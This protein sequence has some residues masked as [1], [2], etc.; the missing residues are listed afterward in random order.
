MENSERKEINVKPKNPELQP[1]QQNQPQNQQQLHQQQIQQ[2]PQIQQIQMQQPFPVYPQQVIPIQSYMVNQPY[3]YQQP[4]SQ[5]IIV[6]PVNPNCV[7]INQPL[8]TLSRPKFF[9]TYS[10]EVRCPFCF[11]KVDTNTEES[12]SICTCIYY[13]LILYFILI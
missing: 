7:V 8:P 3:I 4:Y 11:Q 6:S 1:I 13:F 12:F 2:Q 10:T 5:P 9:S